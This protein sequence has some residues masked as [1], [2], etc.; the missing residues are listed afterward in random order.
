MP[1]FVARALLVSMPTFVARALLAAV[2]LTLATACAGSFDLERARHALSRRPQLEAPVLLP[3]PASELPAPEGVA[4]TSGQLREVPLQWEPVITGDVGGYVVERA[5]APNGPFTRVA[6]LAGRNTTLWVDRGAPEGSPNG[7]PSAL[8]DG[9]TAY[10][11]VRSFAR[12]G[13]LGAEATLVASATT[14]SPPAPPPALRAYSHQPRQVPLAWRASDDPNVTAYRVYRS[15]SFRGSFERLA[16]VDGRFQTIYNDKGLGDLRVFY[17]RVAAVNRAGGEGRAS[18][19]VRAVTKPAPLPPLGLRVTEQRL[20]VNQL[21]W[22]PNVETNLV[23]YRLLRQRVGAKEREPV[24]TLTPDQ[25]TAEDP[26]ASADERIDYTLVAVDEDGLASDPAEP[27]V[28]TSVGYEISAT[29][30]TDGVHLAWNPRSE[31]GFSGARVY[32]IGALS[33]NELAFVTGG[34][35]VDTQAKPGGRYRYTVVL[36]R[37]DKTLAPASPVVEIQVPKG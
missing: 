23:G 32:R 28:V 10:Y 34:S 11:R 2:A 22:E 8:A 36:E 3:G 35:F 18:E 5:F 14:A 16:T 9:V 24:A 31:E 7:T 1:T 17:Y 12:S 20:G 29:A 26:A 33:R 30:R 15:P 13:Q 37:A 4:A 6:V 25:I 21:S 19:P 27:V